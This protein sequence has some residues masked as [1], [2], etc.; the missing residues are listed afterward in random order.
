MENWQLFEQECCNYLNNALK[1]YP[2]NFKCNGGSDSTS[3]DI[4]VTKKNASVFSIEAKLSPSQS[5]QFV[6]LD[7]NNKFSYSPRNKFSGNIYSR[8]IIDYLN[9]NIDLYTNVQQSAI[10]IKCPNG[11][12]IGWIK[13]HYKAKGSKF[14]ITST[15]LGTNK[16][17]VPLD[18][19]GQYFVVS[20]CLRRKKSGSRNIPKSDFMFAERLVQEHLRN[21]RCK[22]KEVKKID[23]KLVVTLDSDTYLNK[24]K[25]YLDS[26]MY[27]SEDRLNSNKYIIKKL[28]KTNNANVVFSLR[29]VG[30]S[31]SSSSL[32]ILKNELK[33]YM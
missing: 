17:I 31:N 29:Y 10:N 13:E 28:S 1:D 30:D 3:S 8:Q 20:A 18:Q 19:L 32:N 33:K 24:S 25:C 12:L 4:E 9:R 16:V 15:S 11:V 2:F 7:N 21:M 26:D 14:I 6:V 22:V 27:I 5:G 23:N